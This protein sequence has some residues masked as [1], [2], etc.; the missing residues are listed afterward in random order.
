MKKI[1]L[2]LALFVSLMMAGCSA[3]GFTFEML[4][5][6]LTIAA[7]DAKD[8]AKSESFPIY[9]YQG[10]PV[11]LESSLEKGEVEIEFVD[12]IITG[13]G[14]SDYTTLDVVDTLTI[15]PG[16]TKEITLPESNYVLRCKAKGE[17][18]GKIK[19]IPH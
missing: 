5:D 11:K 6:E 18:T 16:E 19:V 7:K 10:V 12:T 8:G 9:A 15:G 2:V 17:T 3:S 1:C 13:E 4:F 14:S